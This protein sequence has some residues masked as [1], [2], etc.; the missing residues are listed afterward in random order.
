MLLRKHLEN[1]MLVSMVQEGYDRY[2]KLNIH[3]H[4]EIGDPISRILYV[5]L[6][7]NTLM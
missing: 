6:M 7:E 2:L 1:G 3:T 4:N 5:E